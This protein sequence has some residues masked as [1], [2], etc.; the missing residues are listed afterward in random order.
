MFLCSVG[1]RSVRVLAVASAAAT[2]PAYQQYPQAGGLGAHSP[3]RPLAPL[4]VTLAVRPQRRLGALALRSPGR[5]LETH[6]TRTWKLRP[7]AARG[8]PE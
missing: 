5:R 3:A 8:S 7:R 1:L 6:L 4:K 2:V